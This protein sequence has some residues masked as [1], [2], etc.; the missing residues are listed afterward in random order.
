MTVDT[1]AVQLFGPLVV[2][3][4]ER[5]LGPRDFSGVKPKQLLEILLAARGRRVPKD[6][7]AEMLWSKEL[8]QNV[9][10]AL[11]TYVSVM[12]RSLEATGRPGRELV[13][14]E[15]EAYR[16]AI[17]NAEVD[18]DRFD[19]MLER[20][21]DAPTAEKRRLL[22]EALALVHGDVLE[23]EP[24]ADW[25]EDIRRTYRAR[26]LSARLDAG[27]AALAE[28]DHEDGLRHS[29][30]AVELDGL[31]E[32][33]HR[34]A[35]A[36]L[37]ALGRQHE[38]LDRYHHLRRRLDDELG[39]APMPETIALHASVLRH[40]DVNKLLPR[41][42]ESPSGLG[43]PAE[44][45]HALLGRVEELSAIVRLVRRA[46][47]G[48][49]AL[50]LIEGET[51]V[52]KSRLLAALCASLPAIRIGRATCSPL[53]RH[54]PYVPLAAAVRSALEEVADPCGLPALHQ[55]LPEYG[56]DHPDQRYS[57]IDALETL[58]ELLQANAPLLLVLDDL[59]WADPATLGAIAYLQRRCAG[60]GLAIVGAASSKEAS[61][62]HPMRRLAPSLVV[63]LDPLMRE[64]LSALTIPRLDERTDGNL[65]VGS[66][67]PTRR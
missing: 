39:L 38:A 36:A 44:T 53:E 17:E 59:H 47:D 51:G 58:I 10:A 35:M 14:T 42:A 52:G 56:L 62:A 12:R 65:A 13:V 30:A 46:L 61:P 5:R 18:L 64:D 60:V 27:E 37:Y 41:P 34:L 7:L 11:A 6:R 20:A 1:L 32:R 45:A 16:F 54:L 29:D 22:D 55:I 31:S 48:R 49:F 21:S 2:T 4:G 63:E 8:P 24:Y 43:P 25:V 40:E 9:T 66:G 50:V 3:N 19:R 15:T 67:R 28:R 33:A 23:D 26:V 57:E